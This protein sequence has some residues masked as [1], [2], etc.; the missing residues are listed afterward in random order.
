MNDELFKKLLTLKPSEQRVFVFDIDS[1][2]YDVTPRNQQIVRHFGATQNLDS[3]LKNIL[4]N[5]ISLSEDWGIKPGLMRINK[6]NFKKYITEDLIKSIKAHWNTYFFSK[7][8]LHLD[9]VYP[10][11]VEFLQ[12]LN[13]LA[14]I[15]YLTGRDEPRMGHGTREQLTASNFPLSPH[16]NQLILKPDQSL[17]DHTYKVNELI[18][19]Q[20]QF[21]EIHFFENEPV[22]LNA[23][24]EKIPKINLY[25]IDSVNSGRAEIAANIKKLKPYYLTS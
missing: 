10:G 17:L 7:D 8:F 18:K 19:L 13:K 12:K 20:N 9:Q 4:L 25:Y 2:L 22:I 21:E 24:Q 6:N 14:P 1:T 3:D 5:F 15:Y 16:R 23:V 11:A